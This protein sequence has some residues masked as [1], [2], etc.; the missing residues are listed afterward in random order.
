MHL[1]RKLATRVL[2]VDDLVAAAESLEALLTINGYV[3]KCAHDGKSALRLAEAMTP[4]VV[5]LDIGLPDMTGYELARSLRETCACARSVLIALSGYGQEEH[6]RRATEAGIDHYLVKPAEL[7]T[8][9]N[10]IS[11]AG[12]EVDDDIAATQ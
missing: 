5:V 6:I 3:V 2:V 4:A 1:N 12:P 9:L 10:L 11:T 7:S 8:L